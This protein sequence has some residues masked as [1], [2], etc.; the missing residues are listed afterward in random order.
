[1]ASRLQGSHLKP[2]VLAVPGIIPRAFCRVPDPS[3]PSWH[4]ALCAGLVPI[5][6]AVLGFQ[7]LSLP[8]VR[9]GSRNQR[10]PAGLA[11]YVGA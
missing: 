11:L 5:T 10:G 4:D 2:G 7:S 6:R 9:P 8:Q 1:M 3:M